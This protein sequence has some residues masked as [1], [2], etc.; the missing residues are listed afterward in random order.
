VLCSI[1][2]LPL[3]PGEYSFN[4]FASVNGDIADWV[5]HAGVLRV[6]ADDFFGTGRLPPIKQGAFLVR[7][8]WRG[9]W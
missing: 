9:E 8:S 6:E 5:Q 1:P 2:G 3:Q 7:H 4:V